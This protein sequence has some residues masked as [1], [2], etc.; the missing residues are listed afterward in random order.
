YP[1]R[2]NGQEYTAG[3]GDGN[4]GY[5]PHPNY[6]RTDIQQQQQQH[7][8]CYLPHYYTNADSEEDESETMGGMTA[9]AMQS[10]SLPSYAPP[11]S[12]LELIPNAPRL[13][14]QSLPPQD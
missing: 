12:T 3:G 7:N 6:E 8:S 4:S 10:R 14:P 1:E 2:E 11:V 5:F 9:T 13:D